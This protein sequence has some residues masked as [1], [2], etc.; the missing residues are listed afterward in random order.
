M[1]KQKGQSYNY[2]VDYRQSLDCIIKHLYHYTYY[3]SNGYILDCQRPIFF[4]KDQH[5]NFFFF[6]ERIH[7]NIVIAV[8]SASFLNCI[9]IPKKVKVT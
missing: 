1:G 4:V 8:Q 3:T 9:V 7:E 6:D 5:H 2:Y